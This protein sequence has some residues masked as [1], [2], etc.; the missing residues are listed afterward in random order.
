MSDLLTPTQIAFLRRVLEVVGQG[1]PTVEA[2]RQVASEWGWVVVKEGTIEQVGPDIHMKH[3]TF[4]I[5]PA[6]QSMNSRGGDA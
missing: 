3:W 6:F 1:P 4:G 2:V 5:D